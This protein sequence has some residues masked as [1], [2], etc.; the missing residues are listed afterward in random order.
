MTLGPTNAEDIL[1]KTFEA[2]FPIPCNKKVNLIG[3]R[4]D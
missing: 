1:E 4:N 2:G 3:M